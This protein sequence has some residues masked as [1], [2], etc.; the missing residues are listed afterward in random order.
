MSVGHRSVTAFA[1]KELHL[2]QLVKSKDR[3]MRSGPRDF[4][5]GDVMHFVLEELQTPFGDMSLR[6]LFIEPF[7]TH[8]VL[9]AS[10][11]CQ[12]S[13]I[14]I[15]RT[16]S[17][18]WEV[19]L[20]DPSFPYCDEYLSILGICSL[21]SIPLRRKFSLTSGPLNGVLLY[22]VEFITNVAIGL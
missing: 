19:L 5:V 18:S 4:K 3:G 13:T 11:F 14:L 7:F 20:L 9:R 2:S 16:A 10:V 6:W 15:S 12:Y 1:K 17:V 21:G 8:K 22:L